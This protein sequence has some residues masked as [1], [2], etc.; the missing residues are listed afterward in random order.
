MTRDELIAWLREAEIGDVAF[1]AGAA[2]QLMAMDQGMTE[3]DLY[4]EFAKRAGAEPDANILRE[5]FLDGHREV[6]NTDTREAE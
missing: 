5:R 4:A 3:A 2:F 1:V 6:P